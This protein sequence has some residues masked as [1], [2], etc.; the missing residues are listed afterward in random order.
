MYQTLFGI[1]FIIIGFLAGLYAENVYINRPVIQVVDQKEISKNELQTKTG[2]DLE[3]A[4]LESVV[5]SNDI[6]LGLTQVIIRNTSLK[7]PE[8]SNIA[9]QIVET[10]KKEGEQLKL[11]QKDWFGIETV[12]NMEEKLQN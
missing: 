5:N 4:F 11:I 2:D 3:K 10:R 7:H 9:L 8:L 12:S 1:S 6:M